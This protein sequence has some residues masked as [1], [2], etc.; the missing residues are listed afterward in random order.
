MCAIVA[1]MRAARATPRLLAAAMDRTPPRATATATTPRRGPDAT[2][3]RIHSALAIA[4][5]LI[6]PGFM[7]PACA[8]PA[9]GDVAP[10]QARPAAAP[11][12]PTRTANNDARGAGVQPDYD[13][14]AALLREQIAPRLPDPLP[15]D[16]R[17]ACTAML[18][19]AATFYGTI[20]SEPAPRTQ[21][22]AD[23]QSTRAADLAACEKETSVR[24]AT[25]VQL[26]LADRDTELPWLID[27]CTRAFPD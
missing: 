18:D 21:L 16:R 14:E 25:C 17:A 19:A 2:T 9:D 26:R 4:L 13:G 22:L 12:G 11:S 27:Q 10:P 24:A 6:A 7:A 20:E 5:G 3:P 15:S 8:T 1:S 23:V